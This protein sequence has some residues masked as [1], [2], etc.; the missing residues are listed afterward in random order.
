M[1][2]TKRDYRRKCSQVSFLMRGFCPLALKETT[3]DCSD[4]R[5]I[6]IVRCMS[7]N[8]IILIAGGNAMEH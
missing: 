8:I 1:S 3:Y 2:S 4:T 7:I 6:T 5:I